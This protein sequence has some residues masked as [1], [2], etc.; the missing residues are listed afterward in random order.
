MTIDIPPNGESRTK[1]RTRILILNTAYELFATQGLF[2]TS[3]VDISREAGVT[4]R[5]F[6]NYY[7]TK[8]E[9]CAEL[10]PLLLTSF[11]NI[12]NDQI[13]APS[14]PCYAVKEYLRSLHDILISDILFQKYIIKFNHYESSYPG[15]I[16]EEYELG[17]YLE[18]KS[19]IP[20]LLMSCREQ[21]ALNNEFEDIILT[22]R[23]IVQ[24]FLAFIE[25]VTYRLDSYKQEGVAT[26]GNFGFYLNMI[27]HSIYRE[28]VR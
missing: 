28:A 17:N 18:E 5:T 25:R 22:T 23:I 9:I 1:R 16:P 11:L 26:K 19:K 13:E 2:T 12:V 14:A 6:Y 15:V 10:H 4:R 21:G 20:K 27:L 24:S 8:D 3:V 7:Q